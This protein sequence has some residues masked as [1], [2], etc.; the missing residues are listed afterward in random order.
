MKRN[1]LGKA[2][3]AV[4]MLLTGF[5]FTSCDENDNAIIING[6]EWVK[7]EVIKTDDGATIVANTPSDITRM[8]M[9]VGADLKAAV[10]AGD[11]YV[12][13]IDA[14]SLESSEGDYIIN[15]PLQNYLSLDPTSTAKVVINFANPLTT[16]V[17][18]VIQDKVNY[19]SASG[20]A[21]NKL[22]V[23][24]P[25]GSSNI[26]M[27]LK[28]PYTSVTLNAGTIDELIATTAWG[29]LNIES[30]VTVNW[31]KMNGGYGVVKDGGKVL[32][33]LMN[34]NFD[35][36]KEG[37][38]INHLYK[39]EVPA[40]VT[41]D[42]YYYVDRAKI[43]KREDGGYVFF[44][45]WGYSEDPKNEV[46]I[47]ISDGAK[48]FTSSSSTYCPAI[49]IIGE[50][51][52][53]IMKEGY[54]DGE[55][56]VYPYGTYGYEWYMTAIKSITNVTVDFTK[57]LVWNDETDE[58]EELEI[59]EDYD[60]Y[61]YPPKSA[62]DCVIKAT[63]FI[64]SYQSN[65]NHYLN[66]CELSARNIRNINPNSEN[67]TFKG[68][69]I[70]FS[71][72]VSGNSATT[73]GCKFEGTEDEPRSNLIIPYQTADRSSFDY[74]FD[75]C[76]FSKGFMLSTDF[77]DSKA[78]IDKDG[79]PV[80][81]AYY[82]WVLNDDGSVKTNPSIQRHSPDEKDIPAANKENGKYD[83]YDHY[84]DGIG[85]VYSDG[86]WIRES[87]YGLSEECLYND[88]KCII[89]FK[90][91]TFGG[92]DISKDTEFIRNVDSGYNEEGEIGTTT[93]FVIGGVSYK[94]VKDSDTQKWFLVAAE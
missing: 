91:T 1:Y 41:D 16:D 62:K 34:S 2:M 65:I 88:Y 53:K 46:D 12:I 70:S 51:D 76:Q 77:T 56:K 14:P 29:T 73:K 82:W 66:N 52:A 22:E 23:N 26:D 90:N 45:I 19:T 18:L 9:K 5:S 31:L 94:A 37:I 67:T 44:N 15:M 27:E 36:K 6:K 78:M 47:V 3:V 48:A 87:E 59:E 10:E 69:Y 33:A 86:Y 28:L 25:S 84:V 11:D 39:N 24:I 60:T 13:T 35:V 83:D 50:G 38:L 4:A 79:K 7:A 63:Q 93:R 57:C 42:D 55:G 40:T 21:Q 89:T 92:K 68:N 43:L 72:N 64:G 30:G 81:K 61:L 20:P 17:P 8:L 80:T 49:N 54:K 58:F 85:W 32:G 75:D 71:G 74:I